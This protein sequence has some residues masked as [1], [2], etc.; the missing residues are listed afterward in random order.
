MHTVLATKIPAQCSYV[1]LRV[2]TFLML[3]GKRR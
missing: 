1:W 3:S 2:D